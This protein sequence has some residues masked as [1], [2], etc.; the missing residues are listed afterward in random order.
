MFKQEIH[1]QIINQGTE[2]KAS[3]FTFDAP[4]DT[5]VRHHCSLSSWEVHYNLFLLA[6]FQLYPNI[7]LAVDIKL[8]TK[9]LAVSGRQMSAAYWTA[10]PFSWGQRS[11]LLTISPNQNL[12][13]SVT[14]GT[15]CSQSMF[16]VKQKNKL[17]RG[18]YLPTFLL[19]SVAE[20]CTVRT[21]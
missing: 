10:S 13:V 5:F 1:K 20:M 14:N 21:V 17:P 18:S 6:D 12:S 3:I 8:E 19:S 11:Q 16:S 4:N 15:G 2:P 7:I 9:Y